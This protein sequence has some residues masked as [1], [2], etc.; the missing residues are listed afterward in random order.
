MSAFRPLPVLVALSLVSA[1]LSPA[2]AAMADGEEAT[3]QAEVNTEAEDAASTEVDE[4][5]EVHEVEAEAEAANSDEVLAEGPAAPIEAAADSTEDAAQAS[6]PSATIEHT[7][8]ALA[9]AVETKSD[10]PKDPKRFY[11]AGITLTVI[12]AVGAIGSSFMIFPCLER[13]GDGGGRQSRCIET[14]SPLVIGT[15]AVGGAALITGISLLV[16]SRNKKKNVAALPV[17]MAG[18]DRAG[19]GFTGRF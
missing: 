4:V 5:D 18:P 17:P 14:I 8:E 13:G 3:A 1:P 10:R 19:L 6:G 16:V 7:D 11:N 15:G 9:D 2:L 12:G